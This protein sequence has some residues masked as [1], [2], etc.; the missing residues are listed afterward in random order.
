M[1]IARNLSFIQNA[2][3]AITTGTINATAAPITFSINSTERMR[4]DSSGVVSVPG[5]TAA[6]VPQLVH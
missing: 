1:T 5:V 3:G 6:T 4:I 2:A